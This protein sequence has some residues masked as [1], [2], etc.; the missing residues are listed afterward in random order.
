[1]IRRNPRV[2]LLFSN[3][4]ASGLARPPA[5]LVQGDATAPDEVST[6][7]AGFEEGLERGFRRQPSGGPYRSNALMRYLFDSY[8]MPL[9][10]YVMPR[11]I[12]WWPE[13]DFGQTPRDIEVAHVG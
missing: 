11:R 7:I 4:T 8:Y 5:V 6:S 10:I 12:R 2:S 1:N 9:M 13:G 3:P